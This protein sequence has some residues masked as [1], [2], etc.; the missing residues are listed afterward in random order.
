MGEQDI[1]CL[2]LTMTNQ[3]CSDL[4]KKMENKISQSW[5]GKFRPFFQRWYIILKWIQIV[6]RNESFTKPMGQTQVKKFATNSN[7]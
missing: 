5:P 3:D 4:K 2:Y 1:G 6:S 7:F